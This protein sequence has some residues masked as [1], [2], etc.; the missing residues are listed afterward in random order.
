VV[1]VETIGETEYGRQLPDIIS[2]F[3]IKLAVVSVTP[4]WMG[5]SVITRDKP[6]SDSLSF[7]KWQVR[8]FNDN[9]PR[10]FIV[11]FT[12]DD[13]SNVVQQSCDLQPDALGVPHVMN[14]LK[15]VEKHTAQPAD[16]DRMSASMSDGKA[17]LN[18]TLQQISMA[19]FL[20]IACRLIGKIRMTLMLKLC[21]IISFYVLYRPR[22][23]RDLNE[24]LQLGILYATLLSVD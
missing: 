9:V 7:V 16:L 10:S 4:V 11:L 13:F 3:G 20:H 12:G 17:E 19:Q 21:P 18:D 1:S 22:A 5:A 8:R 23:T 2:G 6:D 24:R 15:L 14:A